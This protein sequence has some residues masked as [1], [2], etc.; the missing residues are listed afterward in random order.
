MID[1]LK[2]PAILKKVYDDPAKPDS[3]FLDIEIVPGEIF[4]IDTSMLQELC[5]ELKYGIPLIENGR[6][7]MLPYGISRDAKIEEGCLSTRIQVLKGLQLSGQHSLT[8]TDGVLKLINAGIVRHFFIGLGNVKCEC[9]E[10]KETL[11]KWDKMSCQH[12][13]GQRDK[14]GISFT[15]TVKEALVLVISSVTLKV[16]DY[17]NIELLTQ[18]EETN[19]ADKRIAMKRNLEKRP[20]MIT[21]SSHHQF[22]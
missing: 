13:P 16:R 7:N 14:K 20:Q 22:D 3:A 8:S 15:Y 11:F 1:T 12:W 18:V 9:D 21:K 17:E 5:D 19:I 6:T 2:L 4:R 10:C